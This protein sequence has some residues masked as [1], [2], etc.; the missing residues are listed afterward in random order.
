M[1][2]LRVNTVVEEICRYGGERLA[3]LESIIVSGLFVL[4]HKSTMQNFSTCTN[5]K[6]FPDHR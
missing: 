5:A 4:Y 3:L 6:D 1:G 2:W